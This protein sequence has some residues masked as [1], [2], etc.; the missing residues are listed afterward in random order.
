MYNICSLAYKQTRGILF[1]I[2]TLI[3]LPITRTRI[4]LLSTLLISRN[5]VIIL[6]KGVRVKNLSFI[7]IR[8]AA[9]L[10]IKDFS[11]IARGAEIIVGNNSTLTIGI[12]TSIGGFS[13][14]RCDG[15]ISIG[16]DVLIAQYCSLVSG[17]YNFKDDEI[18]IYKTE[19]ICE[20]IE[21]G[22]N[23]WIGTHSVILPG[24]K[25][26]KGTII[27]AGSIVTKDIPE[28]S[29]VAGNPAKII[30]SR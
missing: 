15:N 20:N 25:I 18:S 7:D 6:G 10:Q 11:C 13:N 27:G 1:K 16:N 9:K 8:N 22:D 19:I 21:I 3:K 4:N 2:C 30:R 17:Q 29:I 14:I 5:G 12:N 24:I 28:N 23:V 26:G